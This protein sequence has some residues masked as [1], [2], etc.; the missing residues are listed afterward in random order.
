MGGVP[1]LKNPHFRLRSNKD[2]KVCVVL[3]RVRIAPKPE[4]P[5]KPPKEK[6]VSAE[7]EEAEEAEEAAEEEE[8]E[9]VEPDVPVN[10][11]FLVVRNAEGKSEAYPEE[12][13]ELLK[14]VS[15]FVEKGEVSVVVDVTAAGGAI[16]VIPAL[17]EVR[18]V[19]RYVLSA[20]GA[21]GV[22]V[23]L[24]P[25]PNTRTAWLAPP[26]PPPT[27]PMTPRPD[28]VDAEAEVEGE[29]EADGSN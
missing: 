8:E 23:L 4:P 21:S 20:L 18:R 10:Y 14:Q 6:K 3:S 5:S 27:P 2:G 22:E 1:V 26:T 28:E 19:G 7:G 17:S 25:T 12:G 24:E 29:T 15:E 11:G 13:F 9:P 16:F